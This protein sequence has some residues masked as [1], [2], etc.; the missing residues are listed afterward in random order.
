MTAIAN[1]TAA[2]QDG[3]ESSLG[4]GEGDLFLSPVVVIVAIAVAVGLATIAFV[5]HRLRKLDP[6]AFRRAI[7][8]GGLFYAGLLVFHLADLCLDVMAC[9][10]VLDNDD[11]P[12]TLSALFGSLTAIACI[13]SVV[14][15]AMDIHALRKL[16][17][18]RL[19]IDEAAK[20]SRH[21][22]YAE[23]LTLVAE[24]LPMLL[25]A[26][27]LQF[28]TTGSVSEQNVFVLLVVI[29]SSIMVGLKLHNVRPL[30]EYMLAA[31]TYEENCDEM[32]DVHP[33]DM[34][35]L[36]DA[37]DVFTG[38]EAEVAAAWREEFPAADATTTN[39]EPNDAAKA[40]CHSEVAREEGVL[41]KRIQA[42]LKDLKARPLDMDSPQLR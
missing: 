16:T 29:F 11:T 24:D 35:T 20:L 23:C 22:A 14:E 40:I 21:V 9:V 33:E 1:T 13:V 6:V 12:T 41:T 8:N 7:D 2:P 37:I 30:L 27:A 32:A 18:G 10:T 15:L 34:Q 4:L 38:Y 17:I 28:S 3:R 31:R 36:V 39:V 25:V 19:D 42:V 26:G 5:V